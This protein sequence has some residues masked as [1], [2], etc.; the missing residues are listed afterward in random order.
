M[1]IKKLLTN[2]YG[3]T[4]IELLVTLTILTMITGV[5]FGVLTTAIKYNEKTQSHVN[6]RQEANILVTTMRQQHQ[7]D[8][9]YTVCYD[10]DYYES[11]IEFAEITLMQSGEGVNCS[12][13]DPL[14]DLVVNFTLKDIQNNHVFAVD[15]VIEGRRLSETS[16]V[17]IKKKIPGGVTKDPEIISLLWEGS[18][19]SLT[20]LNKDGSPNTTINIKNENGVI[21]GS[22]DSHSDGSIQILGNLF[23]GEIVF[24]HAIAEG[25][26]I[27]REV[28]TTVLSLTTPDNGIV[29]I[30]YPD[31]SREYENFDNSIESDEKII[32]TSSVGAYQTSSNKDNI[33]LDG[34]KGVVIED[35][36]SLTV[37]SS[38][39][40]NLTINSDNGDIIMN[41]VDL[42]NSSH[43]NDFGE[44]VLSATGHIELRN[45]S[46]EAERNITL[47]AGGNIDA[48]SAS[49][50]IGNSGNAI[51]EFSL[52]PNNGIIYVE[53]LHLNNNA[54]AKPVAD[55]KLCGQ[56]ASG[57]INNDIAFTDC[58]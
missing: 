7:G 37:S 41:N 36:V 10:E 26:S 19:K 14:V 3:I 38:G 29:I 53:G 32:V 40:G 34:K 42:T 17:V 15:T 33:L 22:S 13:T 4:L 20:V 25:K 39:Q 58:N 24:V 12:S 21:I 28:S 48:K 54:T 57:E 46:L 8:Q 1:M 27:S 43:A 6:L 9:A 44:V 45:S 5:T 51:I 31:G 49:M 35:G 50:S 23:A 11:R 18:N 56:L 30:E 47:T 52:Q 16:N 2:S 55:V